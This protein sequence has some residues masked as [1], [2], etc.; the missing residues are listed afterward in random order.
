MVASFSGVD[1]LWIGVHFF[2][3]I[4]GVFFSFMIIFHEWGNDSF[5][6][7]EDCGGFWW[8]IHRINRVWM[9]FSVDKPPSLREV[10]SPPGEDGRSGSAAFFNALL[11]GA[12]VGANCVRPPRCR[13]GLFALWCCLA[14]LLLMCFYAALFFS[15][16]RKEPKAAR[17]R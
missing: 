14:L 5:F 15:S 4:C 8:F 7:G 13:L 16:R 10:D 6:Q 11:G 17:G 12:I 3:P 2:H 9:D 1:D